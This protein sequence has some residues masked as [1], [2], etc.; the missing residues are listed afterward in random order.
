MDLKQEQQKEL[1]AIQGA[2]ELLEAQVLASEEASPEVEGSCQEVSYGQP[3]KASRK[4][5]ACERQSSREG[6]RELERAR[7]RESWRELES[8]RE[9]RARESGGERQ[10]DREIEREKERR[11]EREG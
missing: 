11:N 10:R 4:A 5:L 3:R 7:A 1:D 8:P 2:V 6:E 9:R